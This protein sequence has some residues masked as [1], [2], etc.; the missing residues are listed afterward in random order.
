MKMFTAV[1]ALLQKPFPQEEGWLSM[2][3]T[4]FLISV[5]I[6]C[7]LYF[8]KPFNIAN[9]DHKLLIAALSYGAITFGTS[10]IFDLAARSVKLKRDGP[11]FTFG[12]WLIYMIG[13]LLFI[14]LANFVFTRLYFF[15]E[16]KWEYFHF[17]LEVTMLVGIF[18]MLGIGAWTLLRQERKHKEIAVEFN[19]HHNRLPATKVEESTLLF[20]IDIDDIRYIEALQ[21]Y[22]RIRYINSAG[23]IE[24]KTER[25]TLKKVLETATDTSLVQS[26]RS[27]LV[28]KNSIL[29]A[30]GNAQGLLLTIADCEKQVPVSRS[31]VPVFRQL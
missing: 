12:K 13:L 2:L 11:K 7:F 4:I 16:I 1:K 9:T 15:G 25:S 5:F 3:R 31:K 22:V 29:S 24:D 28:N 10:L 30:D 23:N 19:S 27:F 20:G 26:H 6:T 17:M 18:P 21:N 8:F 14:S